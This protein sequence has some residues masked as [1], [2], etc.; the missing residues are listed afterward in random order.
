[1]HVWRAILLLVL[2]HNIDPWRYVFPITIC[3]ISILETLIWMKVWSLL[4]K[5]HK[6]RTHYFYSI[7]LSKLENFNAG[8]SRC[9]VS[10]IAA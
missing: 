8:N 3:K 5:S 6:M 9:K 1:M 2:L 7:A 4:T 10:E